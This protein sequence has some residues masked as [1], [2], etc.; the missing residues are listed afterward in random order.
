MKT[1]N[2]R[3]FF[4]NKRQFLLQE[5]GS[6]ISY[7]DNDLSLQYLTIAKIVQNFLETAKNEN[8]THLKREGFKKNFHEIYDGILTQTLSL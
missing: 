3:G 4:T 5:S 1:C 8:N 2:L 6:K 7:F